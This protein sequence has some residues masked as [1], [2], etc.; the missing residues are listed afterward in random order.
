ME[1][2]KIFL[3]VSHLLLLLNKAC[4]NILGITLKKMNKQRI[5]ISEIVI[6]FLI[7]K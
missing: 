3:H 6:F 2:L 7:S 4:I 1:L 5:Y